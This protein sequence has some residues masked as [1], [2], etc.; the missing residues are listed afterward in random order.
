MESLAKILAD[1]TFAQKRE[2][3]RIVELRFGEER[4]R[5]ELAQDHAQSKNPWTAEIYIMESH[6]WKLVDSPWIHERDAEAALRLALS[7]VADMKRGLK[8][9]N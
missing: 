5:V 1:F 6:V 9:S 8:T 7:F 4:Y 2:V 3:Q